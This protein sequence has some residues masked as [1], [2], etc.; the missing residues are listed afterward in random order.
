VLCCATDVPDAQRRCRRSRGVVT[1]NFLALLCGPLPI[2]RCVP[3]LVSAFCQHARWCF[4][5]GHSCPFVCSFVSFCCICAAFARSRRHHCYDRFGPPLCLLLHRAR[6]EPRS[7]TFC[8]VLARTRSHS[9]V[10]PPLS[11][12]RLRLL[13]PPPLWVPVC[14]LCCVRQSVPRMSVSVCFMFVCFFSVFSL[15]FAHARYSQCAEGTGNKAVP[16]LPIHCPI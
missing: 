16:P 10:C 12:H 4:A 8:L 13:P 3:V 2:S 7:S 11:V 14:V 15:T 1:F 6:A 5:L 9:P